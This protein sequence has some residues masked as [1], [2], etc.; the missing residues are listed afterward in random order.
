M[1]SDC[2][3]KNLSWNIFKPITSTSLAKLCFLIY[4]NKF[5]IE[6]QNSIP[7]T[8]KQW[9]RHPIYDISLTWQWD[10]YLYF[11]QLMWERTIDIEHIYVLYL[12]SVLYV[13]LGVMCP[14]NEKW[15]LLSFWFSQ[16][17]QNII[18]VMFLLH[19]GGGAKKALSSIIGMDLGP[20]RLPITDPTPEEFKAMKQDVDDLGIKAI[21]WWGQVST[22]TRLNIFL[23]LRYLRNVC[24][25]INI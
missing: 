3:S 5:N 22:E 8:A 15:Q 10:R 12:W 20:S 9:Y 7:D 13:N 21:I 23:N 11:Y 16:H 25:F 19:L 1:W 14:L 17:F 4:V 2:N 18:S 6:I 24:D